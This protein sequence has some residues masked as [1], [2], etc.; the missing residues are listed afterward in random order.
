MWIW[1]TIVLHW[2]DHC[3]LRFSLKSSTVATS[4]TYIGNICCHI[5]YVYI[6]NIIH[7]IH[8]YTVHSLSV[9]LRASIYALQYKGNIC[10]RRLLLMKPDVNIHTLILSNSAVVWRT[11]SVWSM[12][13]MELMHDSSECSILH[14]VLH[15]TCNQ[16]STCVY[17]C[18]FV[19]WSRTH[20]HANLGVEP[21]Q[22]G[23]VYSHSYGHSLCKWS[24]NTVWW[25]IFTISAVEEPSDNR[26]P[27]N[28]YKC[29]Q[30]HMHTHA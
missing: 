17:T 5:L 2:W 28:A 18:V 19:P 24:V 4:S 20:M 23:V 3:K 6:G 22:G 27:T 14:F 30:T 11:V 9:Q 26:E 29:I 12:S 10:C 25:Q 13:Q 7:I 1:L 8:T 16:S 15:V 21:R